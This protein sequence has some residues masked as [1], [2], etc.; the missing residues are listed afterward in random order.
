MSQTKQPQKITKSEL[1][2]RLE[3][4]IP[5]DDQI[6]IQPVSIDKSKRFGS[7]VWAEQFDMANITDYHRFLTEETTEIPDWACIECPFCKKKIRKSNIRKIGACFNARNLGDI[8][9]EFICDNFQ[10]IETVYFREALIG[11]TLAELVNDQ[12][13]PDSAPM[14]EEEMYKAGYN[15]V[16][17]RLSKLDPLDQLGQLGQKESD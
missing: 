8:F 6:V 3:Q 4:Q 1:I 13:G 10:M 9:I 7:D 11:T 2:K 12:K 14:T 16:M 17:E 15:N 5:D